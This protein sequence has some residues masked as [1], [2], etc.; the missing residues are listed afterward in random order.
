MYRS[1]CLGA[2]DL[3]G[4]RMLEL[5]HSLK[6][7]RAD[8]GFTREPLHEVYSGTNDDTPE[9]ITNRNSRWSIMRRGW[10]RNTLFKTNETSYFVF[11]IEEATTIKEP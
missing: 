5:G 4:G 2:A 7:G 8:D 10:G 1:D 9:E 6:A 11:S 3:Y